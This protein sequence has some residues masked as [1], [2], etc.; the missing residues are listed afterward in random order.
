MKAVVVASGITA[1]EDA[2][3]L[4]D[5]K[6]I[7]AADAGALTLERWGRAPHAIVGDMD[8]LGEERAEALARRGV[9]L[10][11]ARR[12]KD[13]TDL[14]LAVALARERGATEIVVLGA[15]GGTRLDF[16]IANALLLTGW[17]PAVRAV[18]GPWVLRGLRGVAEIAIEAPPGARVTLVAV[19]D[20]T[21]VTTRDLRF[22][23]RGEPLRPGTGRGVSNEVSGAD[24]GVRCDGGALLVAEERGVHPGR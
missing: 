7:V 14:E 18:R 1:P 16:D 20:G 6:L 5:A 10:R 3:E 17:G 19:G 12:D 23:L 22:P 21:I 15:F 11:R 13:E 4:E 2:G 24:A 9:E 8:S